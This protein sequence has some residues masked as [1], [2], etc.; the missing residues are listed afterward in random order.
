MGN[1]DKQQDA[2]QLGSDRRYLV[3][4]IGFTCLYAVCVSFFYSSWLVGRPGFAP[5]AFDN[6]LNP[7]ILAASLLFSLL[8]RSKL[9]L[10]RTAC[11]A[12]GYAGFAL[13][14]GG[15]FFAATKSLDPAVVAASAIAAGI[16]MG[17]V[18]PFYF[19]AFAR[20]SSRRIAIAFGIMSLGGMA[21]NMLLGFAPLI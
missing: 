5:T 6:V 7:S 19:E 8:V 14:L 13:A 4:V 10:G 21:A 15:T 12:A 2:G 9:P 11:L 18:M 20:Y 17:L 1:T 16:G 3:A